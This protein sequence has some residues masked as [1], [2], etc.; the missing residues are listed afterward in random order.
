MN[1]YLCNMMNYE[2]LPQHL[3]QLRRRNSDLSSENHR[4]SKLAEI[5]E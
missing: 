5:V 2:M 1:A 3:C 4:A